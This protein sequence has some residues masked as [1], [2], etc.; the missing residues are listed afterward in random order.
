[1]REREYTLVYI[2][3]VYR[4]RNMRRS[5]TMI[6]RKSPSY[7]EDYQ[8][9]TK[10]INLRV[11]YFIFLMH[12]IIHILISP[13]LFTRLCDSAVTTLDIRCISLEGDVVAERDVV[14]ERD[15]VAQ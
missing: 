5:I 14:V 10:Q 4:I 7:L 12:S 15:V 2:H 8:K 9:Y 11:L 6:N 13:K 1:M 3:L